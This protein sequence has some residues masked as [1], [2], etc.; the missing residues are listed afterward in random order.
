[1]FAWKNHGRSLGRID[2][3]WSDSL[4]RMVI[5]REIPGALVLNLTPGEHAVPQTPD[6]IF[7]S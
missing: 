3:W 6:R 2:G 7:L 4:P 1:M 5:Q